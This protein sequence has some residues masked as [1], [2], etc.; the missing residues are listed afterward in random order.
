MGEFKR[1]VDA[2]E[3]AI[4]I[5]RKGVEFYNKLSSAAKS[6]QA[7]DAFSFLAAE[8]ERHLGVF[9]DMLE[10]AAD[11]QPRY[12]YPGEYGMFIESAASGI[13]EKAQKAEGFL[14][15]QDINAS[16]EAGIEIEKETIAFYSEIMEQFDSGN[17]QLL[18]GVIKEEESHWQ[19]KF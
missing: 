17:K 4:R 10:K 7:K 1:A 11:Y 12:N 6:P 15:A 16:I 2:L 19:L 3:A 9:R 5:E 18:Q 14:A 8:E 13:F